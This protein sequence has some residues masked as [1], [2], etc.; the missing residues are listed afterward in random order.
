MRARAAFAALATCAALYACGETLAPSDD[1]AANDGGPSAD[2]PLGDGDGNAGA[3]AAADVV[4]GGC[5]IGAPFG[6]PKDVPVG[7]SYSV[8]AARFNDGRTFAYL[9][10][11]PADGNKVACDLYQSPYVNDS[12]NN[13]TPLTSVSSPFYD[14]Y[15]SVTSDGEYLVFG[16]L[17]DGG[18]KIFVAAAVNASFANATPREQRFTT[19]L[20]NANEPYV[21][22]TGKALYFGATATG[23][24][25]YEIYRTTSWGTDAAAPIAKIDELSVPEASVK[26]QAPVVTNDELEIFWASD[27]GLTG[28]GLDIHRAS[29]AATTDKFGTPEH[30]ATLSNDGNDWPVWISPDRCDLYF[31]NKTPAGLATLRV[32]SR[33]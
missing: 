2:A 26:N 24:S 21:L 25:D 13:H 8:E 27:R 10:L 32:A 28:V 20:T 3:D 7:G 6:P 22:G 4:D 23:T 15:P 11:C 14:S 30:L 29:R 1:G 9:A 5:A 17:R 31:I 16:S 33:R 18:L 19:P 12:F